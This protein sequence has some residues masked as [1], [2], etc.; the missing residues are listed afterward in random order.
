MLRYPVFIGAVFVSF[1]S[2]LPAFAQDFADAESKVSLNP[3]RQV[4]F[5]NFHVHTNYSFDAFANG[6]VTGP[7]D[8]YRWAQGEPIAAGGGLDSTIKIKKPLDW[9][10]VSDHAEYLGIVPKMA[11]PGNPLGEMPVAKLLTSKDPVEG[12]EGYKQI[13][14][15][16]STNKPDPALVEP[17]VISSIWQ[18]VVKT[19]DNYYQPGEFT[20]FPG[21]E[22][23]SNPSNQ[24]LH[25]VVVM[26]DSTHVPKLPFSAF[27]SDREEDLWKWMDEMR[28]DGIP[29]LA[30]PHNGNASN[31]LMFPEETTYGGSKITKEYAETRMRNEPLYEI[32]QIKGTSEVY[33]ALAPNDEFANFE[34]WDY[35]LGADAVPPEKKVGGYIRE[36]MGR[37]LKLE[38]DGTGNP[39]KYG[40]IGDSDTHN[41]ASPIEEDNYTGKF[42][43]ESTPQHRL[44]GVEGV[45]EANAKQIR[46]FSSAGVAAIWA[47]ANTRPSL[48]AAVERKETYATSGPRMTLRVFGGYDFGADPMKADWVHNAY[49]KGVPMGGDLGAP[50]GKAPTFL[51][52]AMKEADGANLD[53]IQMIKGWVSPGGEPREKIYDIA[54]SDGR[55]PRADGKVP[56]VGNT[57]NAAAANYTNDI[58]ETELSAVW[59]DPDFDPASHAF[60]YVRL[61]E[62]PTPRWSTYDAKTLGQAP[63]ADLPVSIQE[64]AWSSPIW[65]RPQQ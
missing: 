10:V 43:V 44:N 5:G 19:A 6:A 8:A 34:I 53:R 59:T 63:R 37:G 11:E 61:I 25:R 26:R 57:V 49:E 52:A 9:Y 56:A 29:L 32:T 45:D 51:V 50:N 12:F 21:F 47:D 15:Q 58:G 17:E 16:I 31:G 22:W 64:R 23:T 62:I 18:G 46:E 65:Y 13:L 20:T 48:Y 27:D 7:D 38:R 3:D 54:L 28:A 30:I 39:F 24:N 40:F 41:S 42:G 35:T 14:G 36:A 2:N 60:Y 55:K 33:P 1:V 4:Y